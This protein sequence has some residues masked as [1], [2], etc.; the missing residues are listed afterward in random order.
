[1]KKNLYPLNPVLLV[2]DEEP[3]LASAA[4]ILKGEGITN[5]AACS[6]SR[7]VMPLLGEQDFS[8]VILDLTMPHITGA[9]LLPQI[10]QQRPDTPVIIMTA[11]NEVESAVQCMKEGALDYLV[12]PLKGDT[13]IGAVTRALKFREVNAENTRLKQYVLSDKLAHP[14]AFS[15]I[16]AQGKAMQ[17]I[18]KY[19]EAVADTVLPVLITGETGVGKESLAR[20]LH[21]LSKRSGAFTAVNAAGL[22]D[23]L[24]SDTLFGH[25]KGSFTG[26]AVE[27]GGMIEAAGSGTL[28]LDEIGDLA[29][30]SQVKLLRLL[31][32][33]TYYPL[34]SD[35]QKKT[36]ARFIFATNINLEEAIAQGSFRKDLYYRLRSHRIHIPPLRER[37]EDIPLLF[38]YF[39]EQGGKLLNKKV[40]L[41]PPELPL[42]LVNYSFPGNIRELQAMVFDALARHE[43][44]ILSMKSFREIIGSETLLQV[45]QETLLPGD[46][47]NLLK[48][49]N[50]RFPYLKEVEN[51]LIGEALKIAENNQGIAANMLGMTR[52]ALNKRLLRGKR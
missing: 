39:L 11:V 48:L 50:G 20:A 32:D 15:G 6:D 14:E 47:V 36:D 21:S 44:G 51:F 27:R 17:G 28:F 22:D 30:S 9:E 24:F 23:T 3:F 5:V 18:F 25:K 49:F 2:D 45:G 46:G 31:Q 13:F 8:L 34:G 1:M 42:L 12:K 41:V 38:N 19:V 52:N 35:V 40:P 29:V 37:R 26:A 16:I 4:F 33:G 7:R 10:I 43:K